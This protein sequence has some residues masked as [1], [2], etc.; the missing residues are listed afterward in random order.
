MSPNLLGPFLLAFEVFVEDALGRAA[1]YKRISASRNCPADRPAD[2]P[3]GSGKQQSGVWN[4]RLACGIASGLTRKV[5]YQ[6]HH[7]D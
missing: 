1:P 4:N 6:N 5:S 3:N 7:Q 2:R